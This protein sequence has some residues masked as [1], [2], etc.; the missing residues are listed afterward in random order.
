MKFTFT[1]PINVYGMIIG[2]NIGV[3]GGW[4]NTYLEGVQIMVKSFGTQ[5][6][7]VVGVISGMPNTANSAYMAK[8]DQQSVVEVKLWKNSYFSTSFIHFV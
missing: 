4:G 6:F 3:S 5:E 1:R 7:K 8:I 2:N